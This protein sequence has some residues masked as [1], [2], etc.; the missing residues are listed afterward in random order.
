[1]EKY[2]GNTFNTILSTMAEL[3]DFVRYKVMNASDYGIPQQR[4][5]IV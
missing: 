1:M 2:N 3:G 5:R 4:N